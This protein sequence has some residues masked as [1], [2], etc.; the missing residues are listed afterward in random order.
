MFMEDEEETK[1]VL[2]YDTCYEDD[3][4]D[5][6]DDENDDGD[7]DG[8][9]DDDDDDYIDKIAIFPLLIDSVA[10]GRQYRGE[11]IMLSVNIII[12]IIIV[13]II[14]IIINFII[15]TII[16]PERQ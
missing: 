13:M 16:S 7:D 8:D 15:I 14:I 10:A 12:I 3:D 11:L 6:E 9:G 1:I 5:G 4:L 2:F